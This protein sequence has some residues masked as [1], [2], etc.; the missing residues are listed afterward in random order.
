MDSTAPNLMPEETSLILL[1]LHFLAHENS[2]DVAFWYFS[3]PK[4][5]GDLAASIPVRRSAYPR[6]LGFGDCSVSPCSR[7]R[8]D[9]NVL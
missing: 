5:P 1:H 9:L 2:R 3:V 8:G 6:G 4:L 7:F